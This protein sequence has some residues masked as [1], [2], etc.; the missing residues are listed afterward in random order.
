MLSVVRQPQHPVHNTLL[1]LIVFELQHFYLCLFLLLDNTLRMDIYQGDQF[2]AIDN[3]RADNR[4]FRLTKAST[5][6]PANTTAA[7]S[8]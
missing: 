8:H 1:A 4:P 7:P 3:S 5:D 6:I 2:E